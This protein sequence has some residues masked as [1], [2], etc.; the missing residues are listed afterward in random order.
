MGE[1]Y[2][3]DLFQMPTEDKAMPPIASEGPNAQEWKTIYAPALGV[4]ICVVL[5]KEM[6]VL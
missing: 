3:Q 2:T 5:S 6:F 4:S 1:G